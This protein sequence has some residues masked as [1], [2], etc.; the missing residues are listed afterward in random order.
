MKD[1]F[2]ET[3]ALD[4][5]LDAK[6]GTL[7][8]MQFDMTQLGGWDTAI[9]ALMHRLLRQSKELGIATTLEGAPDGMSRLLNFALNRPLL[10]AAEPEPPFNLLRSLGDFALNAKAATERV[11]TFVGEIALSF[12]RL[13]RGE[14]YFRPED[15]VET[16]ADSGPR[17]LA[18]VTLISFL[19]GLILAFVGSMQLREFGAQIFVA[20]LVGIAM[21]REMGAMMTGIIMAGRTGASYA[22]RIGTMQVN[23]EIDALQTTGLNP[24]DFLTLPRVLALILM[25]PLLCLYADAVGIAGG[26]TIG[27]FM[28][29]LSPAEYWHQTLGAISLSDFCAG[30]IKGLVFAIVVGVAGCYHGLR[31]GRSSEAVGKVTTVAVVSAIVYIIITDAMLTVVYDILDF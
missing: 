22:A 8:A 14:A 25:V 1:D 4:A 27:V 7:K 3:D 15:F 13:I 18:I 31:C 12:T 30:L 24:I 11:V 16:I 21:A 10:A 9:V 17:A 6:S 28:L 26:M 29:D 5:V 2:P 23:E 19:V 20:D